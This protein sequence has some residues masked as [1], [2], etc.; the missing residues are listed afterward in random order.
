MN[1]KLLYLKRMALGLCLAFCSVSVS[2]EVY[3]NETFN[4][5]GSGIPTGW[6]SSGDIAD[7][8]K[9]TA[10]GQGLTG[11][12]LRFDSHCGGGA[13]C[14]DK[15][16]EGLSDVILTP[17]VTVEGNIIVSFYYR[18]QGAGDFA[19]YVSRD[20]GA[21]YLD[22]VVLAPIQ[23]VDAWTLC[24]VAV[25]ANPGDQVKLV[26]VAK[27]N[28]SAPGQAAYIYIDDVK[29]EDVPTC[30]RAIGL[31]VSEATPTEV[32][33]AWQTLANAGAAPSFY[34]IDLYAGNT[35]VRTERAEDI[36][37]TLKD[38][39][40]G[41]AYTAIIKG[42][43]TYAYQLVSPAATMTFTT[44]CQ[45]SALPYIETFDAQ[46]AGAPACWV[47]GG[48]SRELPAV[49]KNYRYG[50]NGA[51]L[52]ISGSV[53]GGAYAISPML[54]L[55]EQEKMEISF[56]GYAQHHSQTLE[57]GVLTNPYD[58]STYIK[59]GTVNFVNGKW[60]E[61]A[62]STAALADYGMEGEGTYYVVLNSE[63]GKDNVVYVDEVKVAKIAACGRPTDL[64]VTDLTHNSAKLE[65]GEPATPTKRIITLTQGE[66]VSTI[67]AD[68]NPYTITG[69][70][71]NT[72]YSVVV[73]L[74][75]DGESSLPSTEVEFTTVC[76]SVEL[77]DYYEPKWTNNQLPEC[78]TPTLTTLDKGTGKTYPIYTA[79][80]QDQNTWENIPAGLQM[81][82]GNMV[83]LC[84]FGIPANTLRLT[85]TA[86]YAPA[87]GA[88]EIP[89]ALEVGVMGNPSDPTS[90]VLSEAIALDVPKED[91]TVEVILNNITTDGQFIALRATGD[92][93]VSAVKVDLIPECLSPIN[94]HMVGYDRNSATFAWEGRGDATEYRVD[95]GEFTQTVSVPE[96]KFT[97]L[98]SGTKY[99]GNVVVTPLC[100]GKDGESRSLAVNFTTLYDPLL[101][102]QEEPYV[103]NTNGGNLPERW[104]VM[105]D[106]NDGGYSDLLDNPYGRIML[107]MPEFVN[108][109]SD[110]KLTLNVWIYGD[111]LSVGYVTDV[112]DPSTFVEVQKLDDTNWSTLD[113][114]VAYPAGIPA[115][116]IMALKQNTTGT[117]NSTSTVQ[118]VTVELQPNCVS[119]VKVVNH[120]S[121]SNS[122]SITLGN[123]QG[124]SQW[125]LVC[126]LAGAA[127]GD[128]V[129][130][131]TPAYTFTNL[132]GGTTYE[133]YV[134]PLCGDNSISEWAEAYPASTLCEEKS[135]PYLMDFTDGISS[136]YT[137]TGTKWTA[138]N[139]EA[140]VSINS[141]SGS[142]V[143][144]TEG[145]T[146]PEGT[147]AQLSFTM[148]RTAKEFGSGWRKQANN[149]VMNV[150]VNDQPSLQGAT[151]VRTINNAYTKD[152]VESAEGMYTYTADIQIGGKLYFIFEQQFKTSSD[153]A[154]LDDIRL[155]V[156]EGCYT[157]FIRSVSGQ[158][159]TTAVIK[160]QGSPDVTE[161][162]F[163]INGETRTSAT[164]T[165]T[166]DGLTPDTQ[167]SV[168]VAAKCGEEQTAT[169][170]A[171]TFRTRC[172]PLPVPYVDGFES[173]N[174]NKD[175]WTGGAASFSDVR[176]EGSRSLQLSEDA[177]YFLPELEFTGGI[178]NYELSF[179]VYGMSL[180][181]Q[182][183]VG[184]LAD[185]SD[186]AGF[187]TVK[188]VTVKEKEM[189]REVIIT[190]E[191]VLTDHAN[192]KFI[193]FNMPLGQ[194]VLI[195]QLQVREKPACQKVTNLD[196]IV[197]GDE[198]D[199]TW[200][201]KGEKT[202]LALWKN[203]ELVKSVIYTNDATK[204]QQNASLK[205][206]EENE[207]GYNF[208][209]RSICGKDTSE[210]TIDFVFE[211]PCNRV[212]LPYYQNF[213][214]LGIKAHT[215]DVEKYLTCWN[216]L[217]VFRNGSTQIHPSLWYKQSA[218]DKKVIGNVSLDIWA[219]DDGN[220]ITL[221]EFEKPV[222]ELSMTFQAHCNGAEGSELDVIVMKS[223]DQ[224]DDYQIVKSIPKVGDGY[225]EFEIH[226]TG[227]EG[228]YIGFYAKSG[229]NYYVD[230]IEVVETPKSL[231]PTGLSAIA[232]TETTATL[233]VTDESAN[234]AWEL[235]MVP[236]GAAMDESLIQTANNNEYVYTGLNGGSIYDAYVRGVNGDA[237]SKW[238]KVE[239]LVRTD[240]AS[241]SVRP[242]F[243][244][245]FEEAILTGNSIQ[246]MYISDCWTL[247][248]IDA[249]VLGSGIDYGADAWSVST[250][251]VYAGT[252]A[253]VLFKGAVGART[254]LISPKL[255]I[256]EAN[257]Y[258]VSFNIYRQAG[259]VKDLEGLRLW[260]NTSKDTVGG[261][262]LTYV[263]HYVQ[264]NAPGAVATEDEAGFY[265]YTA[266][267]PMADNAL[268]VIFEG[269]SQGGADLYIDNILVRPLPTCR[270]PDRV[271]IAG[272]TPNSVTLDIV[273]PIGT[274]WDVAV[275][276]RDSLMEE[277]YAPVVMTTVNSKNPTIEG[278][279]SSESYDVYVRTNCGNEVSEWT[280][281][282]KFMAPCEAITI[283]KDAP[284]TE[285]F[286][287]LEKDSKPKCWT[288]LIIQKGT[289]PQ[290]DMPRVYN[291]SYYAP[292]GSQMLIM[293]TCMIATPQF[294]NNVRELN[295]AF[296]TRGY[297]N[298]EVGV[299]T[300][301]NDLSTY[302]P[303]VLSKGYQSENVGAASEVRHEVSLASYMGPE[304]HYI[305]FRNLDPTTIYFDLLEITLADP[306]FRIDGATITDVTYSSAKLQFSDPRTQF[307]YVVVE[308]GQPIDAEA[309]VT[310]NNLSYEFTGL[311]ANTTYDAYV[312]PYCEGEPGPWS[313]PV[314]F[315]TLCDVETVTDENPSIIMD[316]PNQILG[317]FTLLQGKAPEYRTNYSGTYYCTYN[318]YDA[319][320]N[321][322]YPVLGFPTYT[323]S[324]ADLVLEIAIGTGSRREFQ[325]GMFKDGQFTS[326]GSVTVQNSST[327]AE[328]SL[329]PL[330]GKEGTPAVL[331]NYSSL[332][333]KTLKVKMGPAFYA[334]IVSVDEVLDTK[335]TITANGGRA[336]KSY[337][338]EV[339]GEVVAGN[340][341][342]LNLTG[343]TPLTQ[344]SV[345]AKANNG[346]E[347][348]E[349]SAAVTF[350]TQ[351]VIPVT[352]APVVTVKAEETALT[353]TAT[354]VE[355]VTSV[356]Y[357]VI[358]AGA[359]LDETA[360]QTAAVSNGTATVNANGLLVGEEYD[361]YV[362]AIGTDKSYWTKVTKRTLCKLGG[363]PYNENFN[364][365]TEGVSMAYQSSYSQ[366]PANPATAVY[367]ECWTVL[368]GSYYDEWEEMYFY[369]AHMAEIE[370]ASKDGA[371]MF[372]YPEYGEDLYMVLPAFGYEVNKLALSFSYKNEREGTQIE[373]GVMSDPN[374]P[375]TF[376]SV[377]KPASAPAWADASVEFAS[378]K[379]GYDHIVIKVDAG[380]G[381]Y[382]WIDDIRV[383]CVGEAIPVSGN[384]CVGQDF[385]YGG[386][387]ISADELNI[388]ENRITRR[389]EALDGGCDKV[390]DFTIT[391]DTQAEMVVYMDTVCPGETEYNNY[392]F[393]IA[394]PESKRYYVE[395]MTA[396]AACSQIVCLKLTVA[397]PTKRINTVICEDELKAGYHFDLAGEDKVFTEPGIYE[398]RTASL[399]TDCDSVVILNLTA[400]SSRVHRY[401][402][403]CEGDS[404]LFHGK[405]YSTTG[406]YTHNYGV[407]G[408]CGDSAEVLHLTVLPSNIVLDTTICPNGRETDGVYFGDRYI[409]YP[410]TYTRTYENKL[411]CE[412]SETWNITYAEL[413]KVEVTDYVCYN[414]DYEV[415]YNNMSYETIKNVT[416]NQ[417]IRMI[418]GAT[419]T[420]C[421]DSLILNLIVEKLEPV[422]KDTVVNELPFLWGDITVA[423][424]GE[425]EQT[426]MSQHGCDSTVILNVK[427]VSSL[428]IAHAGELTLRP[429]PVE[430]DQVIAVDY[431]FSAQE[432]E[433]MII[434]VVNSL[435]QVV[436]RQP[437]AE[438]V[439]VEPI[440]VSGFYTVRFITGENTYYTAKV[441]VK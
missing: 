52:K 288:P 341:A 154:R 323:N 58:F 425:W 94:V 437:A 319:N 298:I 184:V 165:I 329:A 72:A 168:T 418:V 20:N 129:I 294:T 95:F 423:S 35:K 110:L 346:T 148:S 394:N 161:Y 314:T 92:C 180:N 356:E 33:I 399:T 389:E 305:T 361:I 265:E 440:R 360:L 183:N 199:V 286:E 173:A 228:R 428:N 426:F 368:G 27:S 77:G 108:P 191:D 261:T 96:V 252:Q 32:T 61:Y 322:Y 422:H 48:A 12:C 406:E 328:I 326:Y 195:D 131:S 158:T 122:I 307:D 388:G 69:L 420:T 45:A 353:A 295:V 381:W 237:K 250:G 185:P 309:I 212:A 159:T 350:T 100:G 124:E 40:P 267:I 26:F 217:K 119:T 75:C 285:D 312:R 87:N 36:I 297:Y 278:L 229:V 19:A 244:E 91:K 137:L 313:K 238:V 232:V 231:R 133:I 377:Y 2:A 126:A 163:T 248:Q 324:F 47:V 104:V 210:W 386:V 51:A 13:L 172:N 337:T 187:S 274:A 5:L 333:I 226:F 390:Y 395:T 363:L 151:L 208:K 193:A 66:N 9:F 162:Q 82:T 202:E 213:E 134:R 29:I 155:S 385:I 166:W 358:I 152:P 43:C 262:M 8:Y 412:V 365:Y 177:S 106:G 81:K 429:N 342:T 135:M 338:W 327:A 225:Y 3:L 190:F 375:N 264:T 118:K 115:G 417:V 299:M 41:T 188:T 335:A 204:E 287:S 380:N 68:A 409:T 171:Y 402:E 105:Q 156:Q 220:L 65:W 339:N 53:D 345:R 233:V 283:T 308:A 59:L 176:F 140:S 7:I 23:D 127:K 318:G 310:G 157:P 50:N 384:V 349:W 435:G 169:S 436:R 25:P 405:Q 376:V 408:I 70:T 279:T 182:F 196:L 167:Y 263:P 17:S 117:N 139:G 102:T 189:W 28:A 359:T 42:D 367:P 325:I 300:N 344:Y 432:R 142:A 245:T 330:A 67:E 179:M 150:Y 101:I 186:P 112:F 320:Y 63:A 289:S 145:I 254:L 222:G 236:A 251:H 268:Y 415:I 97:G 113:L 136:C 98:T 30:A 275:M 109:L 205:W 403:I 433:G 247:K 296:T 392:G 209:A 371:S 21:T 73:K 331:M 421:G 227:Y 4:S 439:V 292:Q 400:L 60:N 64:K 269:I 24:E 200:E 355:G 351:D 311:Q 103:A 397:Y 107:A 99:S 16:M 373:V 354:V 130:T 111:P 374:D 22:N 86:A 393:K 1:K 362:R 149:N 132:K 37:H 243:A 369:N 281:R 147:A 203:N 424:E 255:Q 398:L 271:V 242:P 427:Y 175:C 240:C 378:V 38:L 256:L 387:V 370:G 410:G 230:N 76:Q 336:A 284:Y 11:T 282:V 241:G 215:Y 414:E 291:Y 413:N 334:P 10:N 434:E 15:T 144:I 383:A 121:T 160:A 348:S 198:L 197:Y 315:T 239:N 90:F 14:N 207:S 174:T 277:G 54:T 249:G 141:T 430:K 181:N 407:Q 306:C 379:D 143:M 246:S 46:V 396:D 401:R 125:Q 431:N 260:V 57:V 416:E 221:P 270:R 438:V 234:T 364:S 235:I 357:S 31:A 219:S 84:G 201:S 80:Y 391:V 74:E 340:E 273:D 138:N 253:A 382:N 44:P 332:Y 214:N 372:L 303:V 71:E 366:R 321:Y 441:L 153:V 211:T 302:T 39:T 18:N 83:A 120:E 223:L 280:R 79:A 411:E 164:N 206:V 347:D 88:T 272:T 259:S 78:W 290:Y 317:C 123:T 85:I 49:Q 419:N 178:K 6:S 116:A 170:A 343:L 258:E 93:R 301:P 56:Y 266:V 404:V 128:T 293:G 89:M 194:V 352:P 55:A 216:R 192:D 316:G 62:V 34:T 114:S 257:A 218:S 224:P 146:V 276:K 304:A